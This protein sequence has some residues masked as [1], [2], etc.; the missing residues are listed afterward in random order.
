[1][2]ESMFVGKGTLLD[3]RKEGFVMRLYQ[4][5][6]RIIHYKWGRSVKRRSNKRYLR[7]RRRSL[8]KTRNRSIKREIRVGP[9]MNLKKSHGLE[10]NKRLTHQE[11]KKIRIID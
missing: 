2:R 3:N 1:V 9:K 4:L 7:R 8:L 11:I 5:F 6:E 10:N